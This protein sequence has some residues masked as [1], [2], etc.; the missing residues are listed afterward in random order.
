MLV[1]PVLGTMNLNQETIRD[2]VVAF[3]IT[4]FISASAS[5]LINN[6]LIQPLGEYLSFIEISWRN[7]AFI[8]YNYHNVYYP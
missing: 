4:T 6:N 8:T 7:A 2:G 3:L 5:I 1:F